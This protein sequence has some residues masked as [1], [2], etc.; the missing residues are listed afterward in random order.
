MAKVGARRAAS[1]VVEGVV[2][3][4]LG[5]DCGQCFGLCCVVPGFSV[6]AD[7]PVNKTAGEPCVHLGHDFRCSVHEELRPRGFVGCTVYDCFGAGQ[8]VSQGTFA[9]RDWRGTPEIAGAMFQVFPVVRGLHELLWYLGE[10]RKLP[11]AR[12]FREELEAARDTTERLTDS[13]AEALVDLDAGS[14]WREINEL[15]IRVSE[16]VRGKGRDFKGADLIGKDLRGADLRRADLRGAYL[17]GA[18][19][20]GAD[21]RLADLIGADLRGADLRGADLSTSIFLTQPQLQ[22]ATGD[23]TTRIPPAL[24]R[25]A[26]WPSGKPSTDHAA[27]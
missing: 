9:G 24:I 25:P 15:L 6:S 19:L 12:G 18:D 2:S 11:A 3:V 21:L 1:G 17:V 16:V 13:T 22:A 4:E 14:H 10:A 8:K 26:H 5:G 27:G 7:F 20:A 23:A